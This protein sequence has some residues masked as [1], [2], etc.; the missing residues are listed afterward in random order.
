G[1]DPQLHPVRRAGRHPVLVPCRG[2]ARG[3]VALR[4][5]R[6]M[7]AW[8]IAAGDFTPLGG[9]DRANYGL[10]RY[11]AGAGRD[12]HLI[13]HRVWKDLQ[14]R[15]RVTVHHAPRPLGSH[16]LGAPLLARA[17]AKTSHGLP[18]D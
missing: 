7:T 5:A 16:L 17:A 4:C 18:R 14:A 1:N 2:A 12:V 8:A 6:R 15:P 3:G 10:A 11:L 9:M 13:A